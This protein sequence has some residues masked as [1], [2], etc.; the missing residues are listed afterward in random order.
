MKVL[1]ADPDDALLD[2]TAYAL[3]RHGHQVVVAQDGVQ[4]LQRSQLE[5]PDLFLLA[6]SLPGLDGFELCR[7]IRSGSSAPVIVLGPHPLDEDIVRAYENGADEFVAKPF[8][9]RAMLLRIEA[10]MRRT[11]NDAN[12]QNGEREHQ[13]VLADLHIDPVRF[14]AAKNGQT[15]ALT[16]V[17]FRVLSLLARHAGKL[18]ES[19]A[20][21]EY[22]QRRPGTVD[23]GALKTHVSHI[24]RK[25]ADAGGV[26]I[27]IRA[28][29]RT[30]Y[31]LSLLAGVAAAPYPDRT[32]R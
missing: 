24:R 30:G 15:L 28:I 16:R 31:I 10:L 12:S 6:T 19:D 11:G 4:A 25:L 18:V 14:G 29:P 17:E 13:L 5:H 20:L 3:L 9:I 7:R 8:G 22:A 21:S 26:P 2:L 27:E 32:H 23:S 1:V